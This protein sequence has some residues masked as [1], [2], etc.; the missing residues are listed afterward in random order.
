MEPSAK[1]LTLVSFY[2]EKNA[3]FAAW[4]RKIQQLLS[5]EL[6]TDFEPYS[7]DQIHGTII[8]L[9]GTIYVGVNQELWSITPDG[10]KN[11]ARWNRS[12]T[13]LLPK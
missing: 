7:L 3:E 11:W 1:Q 9:D 2:G 10:K 4:I 5:A 12:A 13:T 6:G 8:G